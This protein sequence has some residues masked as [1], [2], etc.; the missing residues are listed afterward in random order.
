MA[1]YS[2]PQPLSETAHDAREIA[3]KE[4]TAKQAFGGM[5]AAE[6]AD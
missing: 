3:E 1:V 5:D 6:S 2:T 4:Q